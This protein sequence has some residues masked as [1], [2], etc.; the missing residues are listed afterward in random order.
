MNLFKSWK[1]IIFC[2]RQSQTL[3][4]TASQQR[5]GQDALMRAKPMQLSKVSEEEN[6]E[7]VRINQIIEKCVFACHENNF[8]HVI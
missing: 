8:N 6:Q 1:W 3:N 5:Q 7:C 4:L 2:Y